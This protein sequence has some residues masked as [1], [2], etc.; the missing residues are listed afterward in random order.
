M[1]LYSYK[2][3]WPTRLPNRLKFEDGF[4]KTDKTTFNAED[5]AAAGWIEV[6]D[7]P[8]VE[9][10]NKLEWDGENWSVRE[11]NASEV[12]LKWQEIRNECNRKLAETDYKVIKAMEAGETLDPI[13]TQYRQELR[14]LYNNIN[15]IDP[16]TVVY[17]VPQYPD[18]EANT[19]I[20]TANTP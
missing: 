16:W 12:S 15:D 2:G 18:E 8:F 4:T 20:E 11:P 19:A 17:P 3:A 14:D 5:I 9:Y 6:E 7:P 13:M 10:P 1:A